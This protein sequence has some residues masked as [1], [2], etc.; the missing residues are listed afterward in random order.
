MKKI[1][2]AATI[3]L[4]FFVLVACQPT[5]DKPVIAQKDA[6]E[7]S[8]ESMGQQKEPYSIPKTW[9]REYV[10]ETDQKITVDAAV[11]CPEAGVY[12]IHEII[13][14]NFTQ[15]EIDTLIN[16]F[17]G[18]A[19]L[20]DGEYQETKADLEDK[21]LETKRLMAM[22]PE[23]LDAVIGGYT[24]KDLQKDIDDLEARYAKAPEKATVNQVTSELKT[25]KDGFELL[26]VYAGDGGDDDVLIEVFDLVGEKSNSASFSIRLR[27]ASA[28][29]K[30]LPLSGRSEDTARA[31]L[32]GLGIDSVR[33]LRSGPVVLSNDPDN[34]KTATRYFY[35]RYI[36]GL[37]LRGVCNSIDMNEPKYT[38]S[39]LRPESVGIDVGDNGVTSFY[40]S[41]HNEI[42]GIEKQNLALMPF[43]QIMDK[44]GQSIFLQPMWAEMK[45]SSYEIHPVITSIELCMAA[46]PK[47]DEPGKYLLVPAWS[48]YGHFEYSGLPEYMQEEPSTD[49]KNSLLT[50]SAVDGTMLHR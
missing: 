16:Y 33:L 12:N 29:G 18:D 37:P 6:L 46:I 3:L 26:N 4:S 14:K 50:L 8:I 38:A 7:Q 27:D 39:P 36:D 1:L 23:E 41:E 25:D 30:I 42:T 21:I 24:K 32:Q 13:P 34:R 44:F 20:Y 43:E 48:F 28:G 35:E 5:P 40:W 47:K 11:V 15:Q 49:M 22:T 10:S 17:V 9:Q 19:A 2:C 45:E 31:V